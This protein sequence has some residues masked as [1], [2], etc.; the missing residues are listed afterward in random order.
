MRGIR[1]NG[2]GVGEKEIRLKLD[3]TNCDIQFY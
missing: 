2:I 3:I 1:G